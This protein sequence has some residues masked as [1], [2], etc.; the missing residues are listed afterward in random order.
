MPP[1]RF[2]YLSNRRQP[3]GPGTLLCRVT[4]D[5][6]DQEFST[7]V[8]C[9][10]A[11]WDAKAQQVRGKSAAV[12]LANRKLG[13]LKTGIESLSLAKEGTGEAYTAESLVREYRAGGKPKTTLLAAWQLFIDKRRPLIGVSLSRAKIEADTVRRARVEA[14]LKSQK[15]TGLLPVE[16]TPRLA[17]D[18]MTF[19]RTRLAMSQNYTAKVVQTI[20]QVLRWCVRHEYALRNPLDGYGLSFAPVKP[21]L[22][23]SADELQRLRDFTFSSAPLRAAADCFL[24]QCYTGL[25][26]VDLARFRRGQH[27]RL[28]PDGRAWLYMERQK[29]QHSSGQVA[30]VPLLPVALAL[31]AAHGERLPVPTNQVYNRYLKEIAAVLGFTN[32]ALTSHVGRKTAGAVLLGDGMSLE[33]V[34][35]VLGHSNVLITQK[36]YC[37]I[38]I[39]VVSREFTR[40]Y[41]P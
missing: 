11:D 28:G 40:V 16:F 14:F 4:V 17:D 23:L 9:A 5:G 41:G 10:R 13:Q 3:A 38:T 7:G 26:Y 2:L 37:N 31:L 20:K 36:H 8:R 21:A 19:M 24:F 29:T 35:K 34:S 15:L 33:A 12:Q 32:L 27:T 1:P 39:G 25:A 30:T 6:T 18:F 22:Y